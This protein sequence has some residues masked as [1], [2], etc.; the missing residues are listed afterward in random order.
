MAIIGKIR[1]QSTLVLIIIGG[2]IMAFVLT[3]LFSAGATGGQQGPINLAEVNGT[4]ISPTEFDM[5]L[6]Q[7][8]ENYQL[9][10]QMWISRLDDDEVPRPARTSSGTRARCSG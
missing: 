9:N 1:Q 3:D 8:Y 4:N 5:R 6:Q 10:T 7:A 2:A